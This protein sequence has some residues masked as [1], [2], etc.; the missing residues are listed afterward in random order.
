MIDMLYQDLEIAKM[1]L[2]K[3]DL[4]LVITKEGKVIFETRKPGID[5]F[6][7]A[8]DE[9]NQNL[10]ASSVADRIVGVA[11]AML[12]AYSQVAS[13]FALTISKG[14]VNVLESNGI[15]YHFEKKVANILNHNRTEMCPFERAA[16]ASKNSS[17]AYIK[18]KALATDRKKKPQTYEC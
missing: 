9:L 4:N 11:A 17:E 12:F 10:V 3:N 6:L 2:K 1:R 14:G 15:K 8:I 5:G 16:I 7:E 13:V 18:L